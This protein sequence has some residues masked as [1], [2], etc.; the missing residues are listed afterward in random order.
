MQLRLA[1]TAT[2]ALLLPASMP[3]QV[4][5]DDAPPGNVQ[6]LTLLGVPTA[7]ELMIINLAA[8][9]GTDAFMFFA[10]RTASITLPFGQLLIDPQAWFATCY[11]VVGPSGVATATC[12]VQ[13]FLPLGAGFVA[14]GFRSDAGAVRFTNTCRMYVMGTIGTGPNVPVI[15][16]LPTATAQTSIMVQGRAT[17]AGSSITVEGGSAPVTTTAGTGPN[18]RFAAL[19]NLIPNRRNRLHVTETAGTVRLPTVTVDVVQDST[20]PDLHIDFPASGAQVTQDRVT[21]AGRV[22]DVLSGFMG[23]QVTVNGLPATVNVGIGTNGTFERR[24]IPLAGIGV[25]TV[26]QV[27]ATDEV[28]NQRNAQITVTQIQATGPRLE[29]VSGNNQT[30]RIRERLVEPLRVIVRNVDGTPFPDRLVT[31]QVTR[32]D[33]LVSESSSLPGSQSLQV[34]SNQQGIAEAWWVLGGEAGCGN[35]RVEATSAGATGRIGFCASAQ[36]GP[37]TQI[38]ISSGN[39]QK[40]TVGAPVALPLRAWV[41]DSCNGVGNVPVTFEV[42]RG[43]GLIAA[44]GSP[45][46]TAVSLT[47]AATGHAEVRLV[48]GA[49]PGENEVLVSI[50]GNPR[51]ATFHAIAVASPP[52]TETT[53]VGVVVDNSFRPI[54]GATCQLTMGGSTLPSVLSDANG[55][56]EIRDISAPGP[57]H[58]HIDGLTATQVGGTSIPAGSFPALNYEVMLIAGVENGLPSAVILPPLDPNNARTYSTTNDTLLGVDGIEGLQMR[59]RAGS[60]RLP[61]GN[62]APDGTTIALNQV[63]ADK[64]PMPMP[65]G[66]APPFAWTLQPA[67]ATFDPPIQISY[68]NMTGLA[69]GAIAYF[70]SFNHDTEQFEI[71]SSAHVTSDGSTIVSDPGSGLRTAGWGCNCPPYSVT[72]DCE[73]D[74]DWSSTDPACCTPERIASARD[75]LDS[76]IAVWTSMGWTMSASHLSNF[77]YGSPGVV[78]YPVGSAESNYAALTFEFYFNMYRPACTRLHDA[79]KA[80]P[81]GSTSLPSFSVPVTG[82]R[83][84]RADLNFAIGGIQPARSSINVSGITIDRVNNTYSATIDYDIGDRYDF[85]GIGSEDPVFAGR[86]QFLQRWNLVNAFDVHILHR[87]N[88]VDQSIGAFAPCVFSVQGTPEAPPAPRPA[89]LTLGGQNIEITSPN[90]FRVDNVTAADRFGAGGPGTAPDGLGDDFIRPFITLPTDPPIYLI[91]DRF[92]IRR[93]QTTIMRDWIASTSPPLAVVRLTASATPAVLTQIGQTTQ[94]VAIAEMSDGSFRDVSSRTEWTT[95]LSSNLSIAGVDSNGLVTARGSGTAFITLTNEGAAA[96]VRVTVSPQDPLTTVEGI[97]QFED[98]TPAASAAIEIARFGSVG[99]SN[100]Q[101]RFSLT[102]VP[103]LQGSF[104][105]TARQTTPQGV[106]AAANE[107]VPVP[108]GLSNAG[109]LTL[110]ARN[111][112][113]I[114]DVNN[115]TTQAFKTALENAGMAVTLSSTSEVGYDGTN[116]SPSAFNAV[117]HLNG[118]TYTQEMAL[119]GQQALVNYVSGGGCFIHGEWN[120]YEIS[121]G[122]MATMLPLTLTVRSAGRQGSI[123]YTAA[124]GQSGHALLAGVPSAFTFQ[125]GGNVGPARTFATQPVTLLMFDGS[126]CGVA[127]REFGNGRVV[128]FSHSG[129]WANY[130]TLL[131]ANIQRLYVNGIL[132]GSR[133]VQ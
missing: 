77:L 64:V 37:A 50:P 49:D 108:G 73:P 110:R 44:Q 40:A 55:I 30:G 86:A 126:S 123:S 100:S 20:P 2:A 65:D 75:T 103:S 66:A 72:E 15:D 80:A 60:M 95:Y 1:A 119:A 45:L 78:T 16:P 17:A 129:N 85:N 18:N 115:A 47:T 116:P 112:L 14:Q 117:I 90:G 131:D 34:R 91:G 121:Q 99:A 69:P 102:G 48:L 79:V 8:P 25:P 96:V 27:T 87:T 94:I 106:L 122:R 22:G 26:L 28:G 98:G 56:F 59:V 81:A 124:A 125:S 113:L 41:S 58:L 53:F 36:P 109:I 9:P 71:V 68:P 93:F 120:A 29:L 62:P 7:G 105:V 83:F 51:A 4:F 63:H 101:G 70:L 74:C 35:N 42:V 39:N 111:V 5:I 82:F 107:V 43:G 11:F 33:G 6:A 61:N 88:V 89:I 67:G 19:V 114:W 54:T 133:A 46:S 97:V 32:N 130:Q 76:L 3:A 84:Y 128:G 13:P 92:Q 57:G 118:V 52:D 23:L 38:N 132:W 24:D 104:V 31:F 21:I 12:P 127:V 10:T